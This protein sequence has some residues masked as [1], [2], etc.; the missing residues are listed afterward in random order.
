MCSQAAAARAPRR[1]ERAARQLPRRLRRLPPPPPPRGAPCANRRQSYASGADTR[2]KNTT[3]L[4]NLG[5][6][7]LTMNVSLPN[8]SHNLDQIAGKGV[9]V[10]EEDSDGRSCL[11]AISNTL[12]FRFIFVLVMSKELL[13]LVLLLLHT[14]RY[15]LESVRKLSRA[16]VA[17]LCAAG[18]RQFTG[19][20]ALQTLH[21][22]I[23]PP[24]CTRSRVSK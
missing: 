15:V 10:F 8:L 22:A 11:F 12:Y 18:G 9:E 4:V 1:V 3:F 19:K 13:A 7:L 16:F 2:S 17:N 5:L 6:T 24:V 20:S 21:S 23:S 14:R